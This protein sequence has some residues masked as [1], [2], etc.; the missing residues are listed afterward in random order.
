MDLFRN[1]RTAAS[2]I[3]QIG[4]NELERYLFSNRDL[5]LGE[6]NDKTHPKFQSL[7]QTISHLVYII[8]DESIGSI[9]SNCGHAIQY[10]EHEEHKEPHDMDEGDFNATDG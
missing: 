4:S 6:V 10:G 1:G 8:N 2:T 7:N 9:L 5:L 3:A